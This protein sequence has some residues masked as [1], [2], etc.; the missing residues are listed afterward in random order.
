ML[1]EGSMSVKIAAAVAIPSCRAKARHPRLPSSAF[2]GVDGG[3]AAAMTRCTA[4]AD[5]S[6]LWA[7]GI[8]ANGEGW[9][10]KSQG[11]RAA[12][13]DG[14]AEPD[15]A[16]GS[17]TVRP[18]SPVHCREGPQGLA[19]RLRL[20]QTRKAETVITRWKRVIGDGLRARTDRHCI[21]KMTVVV[22]VLNRMLTF[23]RPSY[24]RIS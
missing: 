9:V 12:A 1:G 11:D 20:Q 6:E 15:S 17:H 22:H 7:P 16:D 13:C 18:A 14:G 8:I 3:P 2:P 24:V 21:T 10:W 23:G 5:R 19:E 4:C